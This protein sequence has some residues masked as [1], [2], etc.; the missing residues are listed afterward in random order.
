M[1]GAFFVPFA[2]KTETM[3]KGILMFAAILVA[4]LAVQGQTARS[5]ARRI[6]EP[7]PKNVIK[8]N[9][10]PMLAGQIPLTN[11]YRLVYEHKILPGQAIQLT[12]A[13]IGKSPFVRLIERNFDDAEGN[14]IH[15]RVGG[16]RTQLT[17]KFYLTGKAPKGFYLAPSASYAYAKFSNRNN[18]YDYVNARYANL[19][20]LAGYQFLIANHFAIDIFTG[21]GI[22][23]NRY[24]FNIPVNE[25]DFSFDRLRWV[26]PKFT[27]GFNMGYAF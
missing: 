22:K 7:L 15:M 24:G 1:Q 2:K 6:E 27:F 18:S 12:G 20:G 19:S 8:T 3:K 13:Y 25:S 10:L 11:E 17:Y 9:L 14:N 16:F 5:N 26:G 4:A 21:I 23:Y